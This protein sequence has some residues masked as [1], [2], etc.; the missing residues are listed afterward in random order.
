MPIL[1]PSTQLLLDNVKKAIQTAE[2]L[3]G[4]EGDQYRLLMEAIAAE[5]RERRTAF[6][7]T[8]T[9]T[10]APPLWVREF[11]TGYAIPT[12]I[13]K[14]VAAGD[15]EDLSWHNDVCPSF[16]NDDEEGGDGARIFV[17]HPDVDQRENGIGTPRYATIWKPSEG[18]EVVYE[19]E[20][21]DE[22]IAAYRTLCAKLKRGCALRCDCKDCRPELHV[23]E[24]R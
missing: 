21:I 14:L 22:A 8:L 9:P 2:E 6:L 15:A 10:G 7:A 1:K 13:V 12:E 19:G 4:A 5:A 3:G 16:G 24:V 23:G 20:E 17:E 18:G 11:G